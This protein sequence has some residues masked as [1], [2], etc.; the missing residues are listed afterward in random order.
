MVRILVYE[1]AVSNMPLHSIDIGMDDFGIDEFVKNIMSKPG[2]YRLT[3]ETT[4]DCDDFFVE[5]LKKVFSMV[6]AI[7][8]DCWPFK[9]GAFNAMVSAIA[10]TYLGFEKEGDLDGKDLFN[11]D[12]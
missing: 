7:D 9:V 10:F 4:V 3:I 5:R 1:N 6:C 2:K 12:G 11:T 8:P